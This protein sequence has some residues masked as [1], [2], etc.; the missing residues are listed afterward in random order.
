M[1]MIVTSGELDGAKWHNFIGSY[2]DEFHWLVD[3]QPEAGTWTS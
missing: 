2:L 3:G 1:H